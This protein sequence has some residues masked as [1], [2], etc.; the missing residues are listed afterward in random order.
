MRSSHLAKIERRL[1]VAVTTLLPESTVRG[2]VI[3]PETR[4]RRLLARLDSAEFDGKGRPESGWRAAAS[5]IIRL[6]ET[7]VPELMDAVR[8]AQ[9][10]VR[11]YCRYCGERRLGLIVD[12]R[13]EQHA[14][15]CRDA[16]GCEFRQNLRGDPAEP[17]PGEEGP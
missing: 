7:D 3:A 13:D 1:D 9:G 4:L 12:S 5:D 2:E 17:E 8:Q 14:W 16:D 6:L 11:K 15:E 10:A